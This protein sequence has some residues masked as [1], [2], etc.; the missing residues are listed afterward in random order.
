MFQAESAPKRLETFSANN[1]IKDITNKIEK[2]F[3]PLMVV[4]E[5]ISSVFGKKKRKYNEEIN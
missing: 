5:K 2:T 1:L 3:R 4:T